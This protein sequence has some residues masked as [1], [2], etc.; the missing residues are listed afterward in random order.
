[1]DKN[2]IV[3]LQGREQIADPV[4]QLL[5][6]GAKKVDRT[7]GWGCAAGA[8]VADQSGTGARG[9]SAHSRADGVGQRRQV[10]GGC[11]LVYDDAQG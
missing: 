6:S 9:H 2:N 11:A 8:T 3:E 4:T 7:S 10:A 5:R 1:M